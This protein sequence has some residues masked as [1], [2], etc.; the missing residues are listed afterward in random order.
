MQSFKYEAISPDGKKI[1]GTIEA[2]DEYTAVARLREMDAAITKITPVKERKQRRA[3]VATGKV[4][5][6]ALAVMCSQFAVILSSGMPIVRAVELIAGQTAD[7]VL[8]QILQ[9]SAGDVAS[10]M[11]LAQSLRNRGKN[12]PATFVEMV[13]SGEESGTLG[14]A[15]KRLQTY[16]DKSFQSK[17]KV[18]AAMTYPVFTLFV[19][20]V[21]V[22]IIMVVAVPAFTSSFSSMG[23]ELPW[24]TRGL[25]ALSGFLVTFWPLLALVIGGVIFAYQM[26]VRTEKGKL[27][28]A[29]LH[30]KL[31]VLGRISLMKASAQFAG[32]LSTLLS[33]GLPMIQA[34]SVTA[35]VLDNAWIGARLK[36][37]LPDLEEGKTLG[38]CLDTAAA[39]PA[40]VSE[41][42]RIGEETGSLEHTLEMVS[43]YYDNETDLAT[44]KALSLLEPIII[45]ILALVVLLVLLSVY[46]PMF[47]LYA[48]VG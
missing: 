15:F 29:R 10:G 4:S 25:I 5:E 45:C 13:R 47:S 35:S 36:E 34:V 3:E 38:S 46:L 19:A 33:A 16:Y 6:R 1:T 40:L 28:R 37:R 31:P 9:Q 14:A 48:N 26:Y 27:F 21:V 43:A 8:R 17:S 22:V 30:L 20:A 41:M 39:F 44:R 12:L 18:K 32:T 42:V 11:S 24:I 23:V 7:K 2:Q